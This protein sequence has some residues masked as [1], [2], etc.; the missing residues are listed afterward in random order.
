MSQERGEGRAVSIDNSHVGVEKLIKQAPHS[1]GKRLG[2]NSDTSPHDAA[3][4]YK[5]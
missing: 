4:E 3:G 1:S 2:V 5:T